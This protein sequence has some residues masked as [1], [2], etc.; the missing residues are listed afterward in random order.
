[1]QDLAAEVAMRR[2]DP[3]LAALAAETVGVAAVV[4]F[5]EESPDHRLYISAAL[6]EDGAIGHVHRKVYLPTY[7]LFDE[8][9]F[10]AAGTG[11]RA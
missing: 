10:F 5:V 9:R 7:G 3:R 4:S 2:D 8:R 6:L 11:F 1:M